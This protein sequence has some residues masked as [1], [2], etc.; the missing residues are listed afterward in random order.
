MKNKVLILVS[1]VLIAV[2]CGKTKQTTD[3]GAYKLSDSDKEEIMTT[4]METQDA[5]NT[6]SLKD[7]MKGYW[8]SD[9]LVYTGAGGPS[10]GYDA[11]LK[12]YKQAYSDTDAMGMLKFTVKDLYKIDSKTVIMIGKFYLSRS[13]G[14]VVGYSTLVWQKLDDKWLIISDHSSGQ[15]VQEWK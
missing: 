14:D 2:S 7:F 12:R 13:I 8:K 3:E 10:Y 11:T 6:G 15:Q 4:F 5:W 9:N 1:V